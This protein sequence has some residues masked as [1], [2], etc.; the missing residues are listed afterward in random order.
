MMNAIEF[1][2]RY[3]RLAVTLVFSLNGFMYANWVSR[4]PRLQEQFGLNHGQLGSALL[5]ISL[6]ALLSMPLTGWAIVRAGSRRLTTLTAFLIC[7]ITPAIPWMPAYGALLALFF[8]LGLTV[9]AL[10]VSMNAQAVVV[11]RRLGKPIMTSFHAWFSAGMM[12]GAGSGALFNRLEWPMTQHLLLM[13]AFLAPVAAWASR[14]LER[15]DVAASGPADP[16]EASGARRRYTPQLVALGLI[17]FCCML[18]EGAMADWTANYLEK[19]AQAGRYWAPIGLAAFTGAMTVGRFMGDRLR[20][21]LGDERLLRAGSITALAG[22]GLALAWP[23]VATGVAGFFGVGLG[24]SSIVPIAYSTAGKTPGVPPGVGISAVTSIGYAGFLL[25][26]P[27]IGWIGDWQGLRLGLAF[28]WLLLLVMV[29]LT[30]KQPTD[31]ASRT[32]RRSSS[33]SL[34]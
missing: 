4:L 34:P 5:A 30:W 28:V 1:N 11:E 19:V 31:G 27:V 21:L 7:C 22:L 15:D 32:S 26:P 12:L 17:A 23:T 18:A 13:A 24:L 14:H 10:D 20:L 25:G 8:A 2:P 29:A 3:S 33:Y 16:A 6:G 9:G